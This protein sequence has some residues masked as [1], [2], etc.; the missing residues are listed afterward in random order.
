MNDLQYANTSPNDF[1]ELNRLYQE[2]LNGG[3][4]ISNWLKEGLSMPGYFGVKCTDGG[5][6]AGAVTIRP[7]ISFTYGHSEL[8]DEITLQYK[9]KELFTVD[10]FAVEPEY[11]RNGV[12]SLLCCGLREEL[13]RRNVDLLLLEAWYPWAEDADLSPPPAVGIFEKYVG[14]LAA[15][16]DYP[17]FY[18]DLYLV[19]ISCSECGG[20]PCTC[21]A[22]ICIIT[23]RQNRKENI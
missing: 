7:G 3:E 16:G 10:M 20:K 17:E 23:V 18:K 11:R 5:R 13:A 12:A 2:Y 22:K 1:E 15:Y 6:I 9:D 19:G 8:A 14:G 21:G 4:Y